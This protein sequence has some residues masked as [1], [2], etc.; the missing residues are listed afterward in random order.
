MRVTS[1]KPW[2]YCEAHNSKARRFTN[3]NQARGFQMSLNLDAQL[4]VETLLLSDF[5]YAACQQIPKACRKRCVL[6]LATTCQDTVTH[7]QDS[8]QQHS[9]KTSKLFG[10]FAMH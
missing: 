5:L 2:F 1:A 4:I 8:K 9:N 7:E 3:P 6:R 10:Q